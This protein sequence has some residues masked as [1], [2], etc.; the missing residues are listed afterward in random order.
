[1]TI[2]SLVK[3]LYDRH[4]RLFAYLSFGLSLSKNPG[5]ATSGFDWVVNRPETNL[6]FVLKC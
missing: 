2:L 5:S 4:L 1:M 3:Y 6:P